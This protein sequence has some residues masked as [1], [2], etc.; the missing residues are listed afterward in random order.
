MNSSQ[1]GTSVIS[2]TG[3]FLNYYCICIIFVRTRRWA[4]C[5]KRGIRRLFTHKVHSVEWMGDFGGEFH[6]K[7]SRG[8]VCMSFVDWFF[9]ILRSFGKHIFGLLIG[10]QWKKYIFSISLLFGSNHD[11]LV[12]TDGD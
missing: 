8:K 6:A 7:F 9:F 10:T 12:I 1:A 2:C 11:G 5:G 3:D 4:S